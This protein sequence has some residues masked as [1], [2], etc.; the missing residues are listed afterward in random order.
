MSP[1]KEFMKPAA[2]LRRKI[3]QKIDVGRDG[4]L[5]EGLLQPER[6]F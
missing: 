3:P 4:G 5:T 6:D 1:G 2:R